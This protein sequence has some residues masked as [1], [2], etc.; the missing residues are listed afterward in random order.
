MIYLAIILC[1]IGGYHFYCLVNAWKELNNTVT[2]N[3]YSCERIIRSYNYVEGK[4][5]VVFGN[6]VPNKL[7]L[8]YFIPSEAAKKLN[9]LLNCEPEFTTEDGITPIFDDVCVE[10]DSQ[11]LKWFFLND[12][13]EQ[14][15]TTEDILNELVLPDEIEEA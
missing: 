3:T 7:K 6:D 14:F 12:D 1:L 5:I 2:L 15:S 11:L 10:V 13:L 8:Y 4:G 9:L